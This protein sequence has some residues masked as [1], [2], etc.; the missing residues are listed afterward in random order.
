MRFRT[1]R[2]IRNVHQAIVNKVI[3]DHFSLAT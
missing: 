2:S 3:P 1:K